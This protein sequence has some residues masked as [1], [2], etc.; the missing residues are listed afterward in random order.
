[1]LTTNPT[2]RYATGSGSQ[3]QVE[4]KALQPSFT[5]GRAMVQTIRE[6][7]WT[8]T[9]SR[10][11]SKRPRSGSLTITSS[12]TIRGR[13]EIKVRATLRA[14]T[15]TTTVFSTRSTRSRLTKCSKLLKYTAQSRTSLG[16]VTTSRCMPTITALWQ[17]ATSISAQMA[18]FATKTT[19]RIKNRRLVNTTSS[20]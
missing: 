12:A 14:K 7:H 17:G 8:Q 5:M 6:V 4:S 11:T 1:M 18:L 3:R 19:A 20:L 16:R 2:S 9:G 15:G 10:V 13:R